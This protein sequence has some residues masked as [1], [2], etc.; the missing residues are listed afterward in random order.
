MAAFRKRTF[1]HQRHGPPRVQGAQ[2]RSGA[3]QPRCRHSPRRP[4]GALC[5]RPRLAAAGIGPAGRKL[6]G[7]ASRSLEGPGSRRALVAV[8]PLPGPGAPGGARPGSCEGSGRYGAG[9]PPRPDCLRRRVPASDPPG[10]PPS[11]AIGGRSAS[12]SLSRGYPVVAG[13]R[14]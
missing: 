5:A 10:G 4:V 13:P 3:Q 14:M 11:R 8:L 6:G 7:G 12:G 9:R 1:G 2:V